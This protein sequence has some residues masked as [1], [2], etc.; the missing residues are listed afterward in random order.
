MGHF[1]KTFL[2]VLAVAIS[3]FFSSLSENASAQPP[4]VIENG[5]VTT[6]DAFFYDDGG[7]SGAAYSPNNSYVFTICPDNPGDVVQ[8]EFL[9]FN[10][11]TN[12]NPAN[13][14]YLSVFDGDSQAANT[15]GNYTGTSLQGISITGTV[16]NPTGCLT[17]VFN[18]NPNGNVA[19]DFPGWAGVVSCTTPCDN[20]TMAS[21]FIDPVPEGPDNSIGVCLGAEITVGDDGSQPAPGFTLDTYVWKW[22]DGTE[23]VV[24]SPDPVT[25]TY[26]EPGEYLVNLVV[27]DN[28]E[29]NSLNVSPLQVLVSTI[30]E[31]NTIFESPVCINNPFTLDGSAIQSVTWTALPPQVV[32]GETYL[33]D[34]A[35]FQF[36]S[37][38]VFDFYP[39]GAVL[40]DCDDFLEV[41]V[42]ME[43][44]YLGDLELEISCPDG[45][46]VTLLEWPNGGGGTF[47]GEAVDDGFEPD[48]PIPGVGYDYGWSPNATG[49]NVNNNENWTSTSF[50]NAA[51][52]QTQSNIVD[53]G[54][55]EPDN[56]LC[57]LVG[58]PLNGEWQFIV[59]DNIGLDDGH[60]F[61]WGV[62]LNPELLPDITTFTPIIGLGPDST[63]WEGPGIVSSSDNNNLIDVVLTETGTYDYTFFATNNFGCTFD[64]TVTV[65]AVEGP[66][67]TAGPDL[68]VC[69][70]PVTMQA[71]LD[72]ADASSC[73]DDG[74]T[75]EYCYENND[76]IIATFCP[77]EPGDG[78]TFMGIS[79]SQGN[80]ETC[81]D[82]M[83][84]Y[85][86][87]GI[88][89]P[90]I[91]AGVTGNLAGQ[92][93]TATN[94]SGCI[95]FQITSD[96]SVSCDNGNFDPIIMNVN[97][98]GG[99]NLVW[100]WSPEEG[101]SNP[102]VQNP[103]V[104][105]TQ[106]TTYTVSAFPP[107]LPGC[108]ITDQVTVSPDPDVDP[109]LDTD[110][111][112]CYNSPPS[113]LI[114][115]LQGTPSFGGDWVNLATGEPFPPQF[116]PTDH[117][118][119]ASFTLEY[120]LDNGFCQNSS[121]LNLTV[122][123]VTNEQCCFTNAV[124]GEDA[125]PCGLSYE[126][127]AFETI[128]TGTWSGPDNVTFSDVNDP[129]AMVTAA[130]PGGAVTLTWTDRVD[131]QCE[132]SD[133]IVVNFA[134]PL[135]IVL[136]P[137][138]AEC[139]GECSGS[140]V[141][142]PSG[143][144]P[145]ASGIYNYLWSSGEAGP[146]GH[147]VQELCADEHR[148]LIVDN[149]G[150]ADSVDFI[151]S[152]P[153][154]QQITA[155]TSPPLCADSCNGR[156]TVLSERAT[157]YSYDGG[158]TWTDTN[159]G[160][161]CAGI[162]T[163][164]ARDA[165]GCEVQTEVSLSDP[166]RFEANFNINPN[167][168]TTKNTLIQF[169]DISSPGPL[170]ETLFI[171]GEG[172]NVGT[173]TDRLTQWR[174]PQ[175]TSGTYPITL[176]TTS[177]NGC[178][179]TLSRALVINDDLLWYI[180]NAFSPNQDAINELWKPQGSFVDLT[181][182]KLEIF[183]RWG[184]RVFQTTDFNQGWNGSVNGSSYFAETG[185]YTYVIRVRSVTT[186]ETHEL[187]GF[188]ML[189]R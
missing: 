111:V 183:N 98:L 113:Q 160:Q 11:Y 185:M 85:D 43:H 9:A 2:P 177:E 96:G 103:D 82:F 55:Y 162:H 123:G 62:E 154:P 144:T 48:G 17:F 32:A 173:S 156:V 164:I 90:V 14:D 135:E 23:T 70:E 6:C 138:D 60:I 119:G 109:G 93:W 131:D 26:D 143:G 97:C 166:P 130:A 142:I 80:M 165:N 40:E 188:I 125:I 126:L 1:S 107:D 187:S 155:L 169:Q 122:L 16:N 61:S 145:D 64:T 149:L 136:I 50:T 184:E 71:G 152:E 133:Q 4:V 86:G 76:N 127:Q 186:E 34:G 120:T 116:T 44:S 12:P 63:F 68:F 78:V 30:P 58:C 141:A 108:V 46:S 57:E 161:V 167:P 118:N 19:G 49:G 181:N 41:F 121:V 77:D 174:F 67:I 95:T 132:A 56:D 7:T 47:L 129:G 128:G 10:V 88:G 115:Y 176:I 114:N 35:G 168:T 94:P 140:A 153:A 45:T 83:T 178:T 73:L 137:T 101:L 106:A 75:Y 22:G 163:V 148:L 124:A 100:S 189:I 79:I 38:L 175:D 27:L 157:S 37:S 110:T 69:D 117:P 24:N 102:N 180:P 134:N 54:T 81:C 84:I 182:Y 151:I 146:T 87:D 91:E 39:T 5:T 21:A 105:V 89:A 15:L 92:S 179:D 72:N 74:G 13:S 51:G 139:N 158:I 33:A 66:A 3:V 8:V 53:P 42:N 28:N 20:P 172:G 18:P 150:C 159:V 52:A 59:T 31:F 112:I 104:F 25:H 170:A 65:E 36:T 29:C 147:V 171:L 99:G